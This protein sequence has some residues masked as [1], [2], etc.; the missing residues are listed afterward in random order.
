[1]SI[2]V[3]QRYV[4]YGIR[5]VHARKLRWPRLESTERG[6][7]G[8]SNSFWLPTRGLFLGFWS[9]ISKQEDKGGH[10][11]GALSVFLL[12]RGDRIFK[13]P[14]PRLRRALVISDG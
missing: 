4:G 6:N 3:G 11:H 12:A 9:Q 10:E 5:E 8:L 13:T 2:T 14:P 1:M 7:K